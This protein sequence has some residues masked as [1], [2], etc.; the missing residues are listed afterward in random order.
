M[1]ECL[2][3]T[4][5]NWALYCVSQFQKTKTQEVEEDLAVFIQL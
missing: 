1:E 5:Q 3:P 2:I 4:T